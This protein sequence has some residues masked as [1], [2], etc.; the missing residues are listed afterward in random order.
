[1]KDFNVFIH[2][3]NIINKKTKNVLIT[4]AIQVKMLDGLYL[5]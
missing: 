5:E 2:V 1:M 4:A 3:Q